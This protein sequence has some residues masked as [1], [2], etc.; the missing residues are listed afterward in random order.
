MNRIKR[1]RHILH[2]RVVETLYWGVFY[3]SDLDYIL[4]RDPIEIT[5]RVTHH[6]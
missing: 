2:G 4:N 1:T 5:L 6:G 3:A